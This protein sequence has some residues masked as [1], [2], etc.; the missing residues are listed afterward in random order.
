MLDEYFS[1]FTEKKEQ[2]TDLLIRLLEERTEILFSMLH[3]SF[4]REGKF[5]D[6]DIAV[7]VDEHRVIRDAAL[8]YELSTSVDISYKLPYPVDVKVINYAPLGF[9]YYALAGRILTC[10]DDDLRVDTV[11]CI[12]NRYF[13]FLPKSKEFFLDMIS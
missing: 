3:G 1:I 4:I 6:I 12:W 11:V 8:D 9:Q 5:K 10:S 2:I 13:D 7:W